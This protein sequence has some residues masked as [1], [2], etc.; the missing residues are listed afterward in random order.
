MTKNI[1]QVEKKIRESCSGIKDLSDLEFK[2]LVNTGVFDKLLLSISNP[3]DS[4]KYK[5]LQE[6]LLKNKNRLSFLALL[7]HAIGENYSFRGNVDGN[8]VYVS[9]FH[10]QWL[11]NGVIFTQ[12]KDKWKGQISFYDNEGDLYLTKSKRN[13]NDGDAIDLRKDLY[14]DFFIKRFRI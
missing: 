11:D 13:F 7:R 14:F 1:K 12:G 4:K 3:K 5:N 6:R 9:P 2:E 8:P 10:Y